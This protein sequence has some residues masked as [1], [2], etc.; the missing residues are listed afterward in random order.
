MVINKNTGAIHVSKSETGL[1][2]NCGYVK[3]G[4]TGTCI[5]TLLPAGISY[6]DSLYVLNNGERHANSGWQPLR[7]AF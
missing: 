6:A 5:Q 1:R 2:Y 3:P 4:T 7:A